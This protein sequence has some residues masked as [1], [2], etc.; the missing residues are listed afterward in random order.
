MTL[1]R[2]LGLFRTLVREGE[3]I[4]GLRWLIASLLGRRSIIP[5]RIRGEALL[6]RAATPDLQVALSCLRGEFKDLIS[7]M[8]RLDHGLIIDAGGYIGTAA[9]VFARAYPDAQIISVEPSRENFALLAWNTRRYPNIRALSKALGPDHG[10]AEL[11]DRGTGDWGLTIVPEPLDRKA[12]GVE[13][14]E[15]ITIDEII[16]DYGHDGIDIFKIDIEGGEHA[17]LSRNTGWVQHT[18]AICIELHDR[19]IG[20][21]SDAYA[22]ATRGRAN[23]KLDG[24]KYLSLAA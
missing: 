1:R 11:K 6:V 3:I 24:E 9:I 5:V 12:T 19:I 8:P 16:R 17:L 15:C 2:I 18:G 4:G 10:I 22:L 21:C 7:A 13:D 23:S 14:V 20:G